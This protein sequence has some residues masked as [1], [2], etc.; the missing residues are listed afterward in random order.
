GAI[1]VRPP[2]VI[3]FDQPERLALAQPE[4]ED[5]HPERIERIILVARAFEELAGLVHGPRVLR[6]VLLAGF[7]QRDQLG[8]VARDEFF[9]H[10]VIECSPE[11][12]PGSFDH[13]TTRE[14]LAALTESAAPGRTALGVFP[15]SAALAVP[16]QLVEPC[17]GFPDSKLVY[18]L[19]P[20]AG[21]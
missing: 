2:V 3:R 5:Q 19:F 13:A 18:P 12:A 15:L 17:L 20:D 14:V 6:S 7:R 4:Y 11:R 21:D 16:R 9:P 10:S 1:L 8:N